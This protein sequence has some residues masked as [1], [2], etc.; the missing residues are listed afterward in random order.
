MVSF[1]F[2][3]LCSHLF[4]FIMFTPSVLQGRRIK[5]AKK[6]F[7][8]PQ[9][10]I[11]HSAYS[12]K[13]MSG[14]FWH[15]EVKHWWSV[16]RETNKTANNLSVPAHYAQMEV[17]CVCVHGCL[18]SCVSFECDVLVMVIDTHPDSFAYFLFFTKL[19]SR[20]I[21]ICVASESIQNSM[22]KPSNHPDFVLESD[23]IISP[24]LFL[25]FILLC[26][27]SQS[28]TEDSHGFV[29]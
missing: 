6:P 15:S 10:Y 22:C 26:R 12:L 24:P 2:G 21:Y 13:I 28:V 16:K 19:H 14:Y 1:N 9:R 23:S 4:S 27:A 7:S 29:L 18:L 25:P 5:F 8:H 3:Y 11:C 17:V 20:G